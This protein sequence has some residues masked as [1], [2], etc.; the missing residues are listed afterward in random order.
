M[1]FLAR[2][3]GTPELYPREEHVSQIITALEVEF[4]RVYQV[5]DFIT[6][7]LVGPLVL[8]S[9]NLL[10]QVAEI[11]TRIL[12]LDCTI[13][14]TLL[15]QG[16]QP[17][18]QQT[19]AIYPIPQGCF[20]ESMCL[21]QTFAVL[22]DVSQYMYSIQTLYGSIMKPLTATGKTT[23]ARLIRWPILIG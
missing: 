13:Q 15:G 11:Q 14:I 23:L 6:K 5:A 3:S 17:V 10:T 2:I 7:H 1:A 20:N 4:Q 18:L 9:L 12:S 21:M 16:R 8:Y 22:N 19:D